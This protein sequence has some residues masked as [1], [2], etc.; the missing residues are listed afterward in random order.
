MRLKWPADNVLKRF[1]YGLLLIIVGCNLYVLLAPLWPQAIFTF[2]TKISKPIKISLD[3]GDSVAAIDRSYD[4]IVIPKLQLDER[5]YDGTADYLVHLG[6]WRRPQ[7]S[8]PGEGSNTVMVGHRFTYNGPSVFYHLDKLEAGDEILVI[9]SG[10]LYLYRVFDKRD[11]DPTEV[12]IES[13]TDKE[14]LTLYTCNPLWSLRYRL[15]ISSD[16]EKVL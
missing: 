2:Q 10:R 6:V 8:R 12:A 15:V 1:N 3:K 16:L 7:T 9:W 11:V 13:Q 5:I 14:R 4:H